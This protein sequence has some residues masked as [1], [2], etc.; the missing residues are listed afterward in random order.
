MPAGHESVPDRTALL[1]QV[2]AEEDLNWVVSVDS[3]VVRA[4]QHAA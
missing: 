1:A 2:D 4:R 3:T